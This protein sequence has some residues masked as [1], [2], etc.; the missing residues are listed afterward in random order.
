MPLACDV[1]KFDTENALQSTQVDLTEFPFSIVI[2]GRTDTR[3]WASA[4]LEAR[5]SAEAFHRTTVR[6]SPT[7]DLFVD[8]GI[9]GRTISRALKLSRASAFRLKNS[10]ADD[11]MRNNPRKQNDHV[12]VP[13]ERRGGAS[14]GSACNERSRCRYPSLEL[15]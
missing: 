12:L 6:G 7:I 1:S 10:P 14:A 15:D 5:L 2:H 13:V 9:G 8:Q 11:R 3:D 4:T